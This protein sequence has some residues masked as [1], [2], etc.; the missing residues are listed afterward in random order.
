MLQLAISFNSVARLFQRSYKALKWQ[1]GSACELSG[2]CYDSS[3]MFSLASVVLF[4]RLLI[5]ECRV[6]SLM[7]TIMSHQEE[8]YQLNG[9]LLRYNNNVMYIIYLLTCRHYIIENTQFRVMYGVM[10][11]LCMKYGVWDVDHSKS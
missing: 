1:I 11:V 10:D 5:L 2:F 8:R 9:Q 3:Q 4:C 6:I 7:V